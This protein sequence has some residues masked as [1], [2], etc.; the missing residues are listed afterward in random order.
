MLALIRSAKAAVSVFSVDG[1]CYTIKLLR[2]DKLMLCL[3]HG[4][5]I[6]GT[7]SAIS[8]AIK[9]RLRSFRKVIVC[10]LSKRTL[11]LAR[12]CFDYTCYLRIKVSSLSLLSAKRLLHVM[13]SSLLFCPIC[14]DLAVLN[15]S[16]FC[17]RYHNT[18][19]CNSVRFIKKIMWKIG[20]S[21]LHPLGSKGANSLMVLFGVCL[22]VLKIKTNWGLNKYTPL[23]IG[24]SL[25][26]ITEACIALD[27]NTRK[28]LFNVWSL[29]A[30][31]SHATQAFLSA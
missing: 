15:S 14:A 5:I 24:A 26:F 8:K 29:C 4:V 13:G 6:L 20:L 9:L 23:K 27:L 25:R 28:L 30:F 10:L 11:W 21:R 16:V 2:I 31:K 3:R 7:E 12:V 1:V 22:C 17:V 19:C 18:F